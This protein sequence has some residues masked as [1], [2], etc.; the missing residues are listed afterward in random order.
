MH[1]RRL[2][3][4]FAFTISVFIHV[5]II[6]GKSSVQPRQF[7]WDCTFLAHLEHTTLQLPIK[8][9]M[10]TVIPVILVFINRIKDL[11]LLSVVVGTEASH[12]WGGLLRKLPLFFLPH[13]PA[14]QV[15]GGVAGEA[16]QIG[17][18]LLVADARG[19]IQPPDEVPLI[20]V[21][22]TGLVETPASNILEDELLFTALFNFLEG[23][24]IRKGAIRILLYSLFY[25]FY[26]FPYFRW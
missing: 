18:F 23:L 15:L 22:Q 3:N 11:G 7:F 9:A 17:D 1:R 2:T 19:V 5:E 8:V 14:L 25:T 4:P 10:N 16:V 24:R 13:Q 20:R 21:P 12:D 6:P 26:K